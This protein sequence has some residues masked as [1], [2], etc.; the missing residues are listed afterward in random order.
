MIT[1]H[2]HPQPRFKYELF[3]IYFISFTSVKAIKLYFRVRLISKRNV[4]FF[5]LEVTYDY[6]TKLMFPMNKYYCEDLPLGPQDTCVVCCHVKGLISD[7][8]IFIYLNN[9]F[10]GFINQSCLGL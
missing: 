10:V 7:S 5:S 2:F 1:L 8:S 3:H 4:M 9:I 6:N